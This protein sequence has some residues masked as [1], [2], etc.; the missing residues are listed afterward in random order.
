[1]VDGDGGADTGS[2]TATIDV[3]AVNDAPSIGAFEFQGQ[4][5]PRLASKS[6]VR[7][8]GSTNNSGVFSPDGSKVAFVEH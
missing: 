8:Y 7:N 2:A 5:H 4:H 6:G 1:M 3:T